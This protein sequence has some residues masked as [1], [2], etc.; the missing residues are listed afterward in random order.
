MGGTVCIHTASKVSVHIGTN[1]LT[2]IDALWPE[3]SRRPF[4]VVLAAYEP[5]RLAVR[6]VLEDFVGGARVDNDRVH[7]H[8][9]RHT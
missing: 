7:G 3:F 2:W 4:S 9:A 8:S 5:A 1:E 6:V